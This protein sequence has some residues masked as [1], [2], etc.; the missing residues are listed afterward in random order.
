MWNPWKISIPLKNWKEMR[1]CRKKEFRSS[2]ALDTGQWI[3]SRRAARKQDSPK[4]IM[5]LFD[6][7][8]LAVQTTVSSHNNR[9]SS[10]VQSFPN[11]SKKVFSKINFVHYLYL[12]IKC[13]NNI[14]KKLNYS[15]PTARHFFQKREMGPSHSTGLSDCYRRATTSIDALEQLE[16]WR[17]ATVSGNGRRC[18]Y[19]D[20]A[21][22]H[23]RE[24]S[25]RWL[26]YAR[27]RKF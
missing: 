19:S 5:H 3:S 24:E 4:S 20:W 21:K 9:R 18:K 14:S 6:I 7:K 17:E 1:S 16:R 13:L 23:A 2:S 11:N 25:A 10:N 27:L 26:F 12:K 15:H 8:A 22:R